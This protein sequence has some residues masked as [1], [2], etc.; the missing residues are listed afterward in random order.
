MNDN[1]MYKNKMQ[2][3][4]HTTVAI[5]ELNIFWPSLKEQSIVKAKCVRFKT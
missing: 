3:P 1:R 4:R 5:T 2:I